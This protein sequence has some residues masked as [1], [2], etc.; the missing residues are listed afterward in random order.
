[1]KRHLLAAAV[2]LVIATVSVLVVLSLIRGTSGSNSG[3]THASGQ[4]V[5]QNFLAA[6]VVPAGTVGGLG[7]AAV[8]AVVFLLKLWGK[9]P[10]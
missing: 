7:L 10:T 8:L 4:L 1:M 9:S 3:T 2:L 6:C 5:S